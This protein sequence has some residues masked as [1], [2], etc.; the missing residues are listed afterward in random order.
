MKKITCLSLFFILLLIL[1]LDW[2]NHTSYRALKISN[3][4]KIGIDINNNNKIAEEEFFSLDKITVFCTFDS[5]DSAENKIGKL[6]KKQKIYL[7]LKTKELF[8]K[9]F[10]TSLIRIDKNNITVNFQDPNIIFLTQGL[11]V[12][13]SQEYDKYENLDKIEKLKIDANSKNFVLL[14]TKSLKYHKIDCEKGL[15]SKQKTYLIFEELPSKAKPCNYCYNLTPKSY[16]ISKIENKV[17]ELSNKKD[18]IQIYQTIGYGATKPSSKCSTQ[19]CKSLKREINSTQ[20]SIDMAIYDFLNQPE[21]L[22]ALQNAKNRGV[23]I[24]VAIDNK[25]YKENIYTQNALKSFASNIYDDSA[26]QKEAFRLMHNKFIVFDNKKVW[27][28]TANLTDT[29]LSGFNANITLL[30]NSSEIA[31]LYEE[32][33]ENFAN[34]KFHSSK[35]KIKT[36]EFKSGNLTVTP[37]FSPKDKT[38]QTQ[39]IPELKKAQKYIYIPSFITTHTGIE[40]ELIK[41]KQRGVDVRLITD[42]TSARNKYSIHSN[43]RKNNIPVKT[44]N[45]AG[46]MHS[47]A[48]IIDDKIAFIG[49]MNLTKSGNVY[50]DE[51][52]VKIENTEIVSE[53]KKVFLTIWNSIPDKYLKIDPKAESF[54]ST[55]SCFDGVDNDFDG[56]VDFADTGCQI[57]KIN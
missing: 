13:N 30:I 26:N 55:G 16:S 17:T 5:I 33:F 4:C 9:T 23:K 28:G 44:E 47:K 51:N 49:S 37:Y 40:T 53:M 25:N 48:V 18:V 50:N 11:A 1:S 39:I 57:N 3:D 56:Q 22:K 42:A 8:L 32:E 2:F 46:K 54:D 35:N 10:L 6:N 41:A 38:I 20:N 27:T 7:A 31:D 21:L 19:M 14:N 36:R 12:S 45:F 43:L 15:N 34:G 52:C 29:C 24:R